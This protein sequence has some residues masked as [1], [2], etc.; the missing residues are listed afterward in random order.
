MIETT[1]REA[2]MG[3]LALPSVAGL[4]KWRWRHGETSLLVY[5]PA[6]AAGRRLAEAGMPKAEPLAIDGDRIRFGRQ[7]FER[8]PGLVVGMTRPADA[9]LIEDVGAEAGYRLV[10]WHSESLRAMIAAADDR[11]LVLGWMLAPKD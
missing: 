7:L 4:P 10:D 8:R 2:L 6:L 11:G 9:L 3:A 1:R 5:D